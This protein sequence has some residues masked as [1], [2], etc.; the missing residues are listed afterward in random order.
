M[1]FTYFIAAFVFSILWFLNLVQL[2]EKLKRGKDIHN[3]KILGCVWSVGLTFSFIIS[4]A[5]FM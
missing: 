3:Q 1:E 2:L 5:T 4:I